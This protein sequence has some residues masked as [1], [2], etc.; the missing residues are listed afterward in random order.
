MICPKCGAESWSSGI[1]EGDDYM[2]HRRRECPNGHTFPTVE[3]HTTVIT[4]D[5]RRIAQFGRRVAENVV[6]YKRDAIIAAEL[7]RGWKRLAERFDLT[8]T[9]VYAAARRASNVKT[10]R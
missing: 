10:I 5:M 2:M 9:S 8:K 6:R 4:G 3:V 7:H 1:A